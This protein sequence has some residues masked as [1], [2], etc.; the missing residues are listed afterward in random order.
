MS[1]VERLD[2]SFARRCT[3]CA[4]SL[5]SKTREIEALP[6]VLLVQVNQ[7]QLSALGPHEALPCEMVAD[8]MLRL[9]GITL[10]LHA[11]I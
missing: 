2:A 1:Q 3:V 7:W 5:R 8:L 4:G 6:R 11:V 9:A 10:H